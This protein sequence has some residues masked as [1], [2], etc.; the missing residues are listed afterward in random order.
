MVASNRIVFLTS[1]AQSIFRKVLDEEQQLLSGR[2][3]EIKNETVKRICSKITK[4]WLKLSNLNDKI[5]L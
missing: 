3:K 4:K 5:K 2:Q 1:I